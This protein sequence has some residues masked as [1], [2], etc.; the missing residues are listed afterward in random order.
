MNLILGKK[1]KELKNAN[2]WLAN[3]FVFVIA[4]FLAF[5]SVVR[6]YNLI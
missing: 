6:L 3:I 1:E 5:Y 4:I 2:L